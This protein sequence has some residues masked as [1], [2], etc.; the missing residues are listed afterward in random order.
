MRLFYKIKQVRIRQIK[1]DKMA[2]N[3]LA[4]INFKALIGHLFKKDSDCIIIEKPLKAIIKEINETESGVML[5]DRKFA[6]L[7]ISIMP[8]IIPSASSGFIESFS[9]IILSG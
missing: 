5:F 4:S 2:W 7:V 1:K 6:P 9:N 8:D 3:I